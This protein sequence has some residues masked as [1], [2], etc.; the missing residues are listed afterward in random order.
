MRINRWIVAAALFVSAAGVANAASISLLA[1]DNATVQPG[2]PR[3]GASG[4]SFF[5]LEGSANTTFASFGVADFNFGS[6]VL[7]GTA[8]GVSGAAL[9]LT[10][11]NAAFSH[12]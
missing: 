2:G 5:N 8:T 4:K 11:S 9:Q 7:G 3:A 6:V 10:Q 12:D 1:S